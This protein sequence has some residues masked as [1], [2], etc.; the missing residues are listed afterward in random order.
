MKKGTLLS[1]L[2]LAGIASAYAQVT[3]SINAGTTTDA[4]GQGI[5]NLVKLIQQLIGLAGPILLSLGVLA[6]FFGLIMF[7]LKGREDEKQRGQWMAFMGW[8]LVSIFA[9]V[10]VWGIVAFIG[11][12]LGIGNV[13]S[14]PTPA[15]PVTPK[16]Y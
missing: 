7:I 5:V 9:M 16:V 15:L 13:Q 4:P 11:S 14:I 10:S 3:V 6:F 12:T 8:S 2:S 1:A